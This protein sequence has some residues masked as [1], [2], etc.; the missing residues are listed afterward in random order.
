MLMGAAALL[1][2]SACTESLGLGCGDAGTPGIVLLAVSARFQSPLTEPPRVTVTEGAYS[3]TAQVVRP[4]GDSGYY[5]AAASNRPGTYTIQITA[6]GF[7][8]WTRP[9]VRVEPSSSCQRVRSVQLTA[10]LDPT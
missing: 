4:A 3:E 5:F 6:P 2:G 9:D 8:D 7:R 10:A 1:L